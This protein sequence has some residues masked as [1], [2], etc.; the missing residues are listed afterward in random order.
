VRAPLSS[1]HPRGADGPSRR[2]KEALAEKFRNSS[3]MDECEAWRPKVFASAGPDRGRPEPFP[4][5][6]HLRRKQLSAQNR[7]ALYTPAP[8]DTPVPFPSI[9]G[10]PPAS[11]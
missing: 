6:T 1:Y 3:I 9:Y 4:A 11:R 2:G 8:A 10:P 7:G 5:P